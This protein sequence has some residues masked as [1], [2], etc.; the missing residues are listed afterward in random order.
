MYNF[1]YIFVKYDR[2]I[3]QI[4]IFPC[5]GLS[6]FFNISI[7]FSKNMYSINEIYKTP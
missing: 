1:K 6:R 4:H 2:F 7:A 3:L 5:V